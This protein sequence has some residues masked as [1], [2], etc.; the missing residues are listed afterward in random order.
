[1]K[2]T[3]RGLTLIELLIS[4]TLF[5]ILTTLAAPSFNRLMQSRVVESGVNTMLSDLRFARSE[6]TRRGGSVVVCQSDAPDNPQASCGA[7]S[8]AN[9][10][11]WAKGWIIFQDVDHNGIRNAGEEVMRAQT[12][13][14]SLD[15]ITASGQS[16]KVVFNALGRLENLNYATT[17]RFGSEGRFGSTLQR[18]VCVSLSGRA[19]IAG[20]GSASCAGGG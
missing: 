11:G 15:A 6:A 19:R 2:K 14:A 4:M 20:D 16:T 18:V 17:L 7:A 10:A 12:T 13:H 9:S 5:G 8:G 3:S 1:V